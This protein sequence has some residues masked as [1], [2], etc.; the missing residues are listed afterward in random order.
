[1]ACFLAK[2]TQRVGH[3]SYRYSALIGK[4]NG[5]ERRAFEMLDRFVWKTGPRMLVSKIKAGRGITRNFF[6][7]EDKTSRCPRGSIATQ[8]KHEFLWFSGSGKRV[9][10]PTL[11]PVFSKIGCRGFLAFTIS[12]SLKKPPSILFRS[13]FV[14]L[15]QVPPVFIRQSELKERMKLS[16]FFSEWVA[17]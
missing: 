14:L 3:Q 13:D 8:S 4:I 2:P 16:A 9:G 17:W 1:M 7:R 5:F 12:S 6:V 10:A 15:A 11:Q